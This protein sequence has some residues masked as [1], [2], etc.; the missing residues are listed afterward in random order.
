VRLKTNDFQAGNALKIANVSGADRVAQ[1]DGA[2][3]DDE[4]GQRKRNSHGGLL[5]AD[6]IDNLGGRFGHWMNGNV[7]L[8]LIEKL[9]PHTAPL[10]RISAMDAVGEFRHCKRADHDGDCRQELRGLS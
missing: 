3:S 4:I 5:S 1:F 6:S 8:Q 2:S 9:A 7:R 10:R